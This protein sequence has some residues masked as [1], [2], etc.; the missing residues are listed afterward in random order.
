MSFLDTLLGSRP[1]AVEAM[2]TDVTRMSRDKVCIAASADGKTMRLSEPHPKDAW[3]RSIGGLR[4][5]DIV[6]VDW[7]PARRFRRPHSEDGRW[8]PASFTRVRRLEMSDLSDRIARKAFPSVEKAF[9]KPMF[10]TEKGNPAFR[11]DQGSRSLAT[12]I[13]KG[14]SVYAH[15]EG[16]RIDF[17][18]A[19]RTWSM[20]PVE[21]LAIRQHQ[22]RCSQCSSRLGE[23]LRQEYH[24]EAAVLRIGL[25]RPYQGG[26]N[27]LGCYLQVNH[28]LPELPRPGHFAGD[29]ES[30]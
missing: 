29:K 23:F 6:A 1:K 30:A 4:P 28:I 10:L 22:Q 24:A 25:G 13:A 15:A 21:D 19:A 8:S 12:I 11:P 14:V 9:G 3:L 7:R 26:N 5:G 2:I 20:V 27:P 16:V 18:D 17:A